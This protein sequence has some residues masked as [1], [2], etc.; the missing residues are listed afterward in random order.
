MNKD[1]A[2][3]DNAFATI[4]SG[5][6]RLGKMCVVAFT[7]RCDHHN[8]VGFV[9]P[10]SSSPPPAISFRAKSC[11]SRSL[12]EW[13]PE[14]SCKN[15]LPITLHKVSFFIVY[16]AVG[17]RKMQRRT[18]AHLGRLCCQSLRVSLKRKDRSQ[19]SAGLKNLCAA[20]ARLRPHKV[21]AAL[22][23]RLVVRK[24]AG[25]AIPDAHATTLAGREC[26]CQNR[27]SMGP[28]C[29]G[30]TRCNAC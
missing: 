14:L 27:R 19:S 8:R 1:R 25:C 20:P 15:R 18:G 2:I 26:Y 13:S 3:R 30:R 10:F 21:C 11:F 9:P 7:T 24:R 5:S 17:P 4:Q 16:A 12:N 28:S 23:L 22:R 29:N 6:E